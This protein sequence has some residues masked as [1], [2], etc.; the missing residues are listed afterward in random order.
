MVDTWTLNHQPSL[1]LQIELGIITRAAIDAFQTDHVSELLCWRALSGG[2]H[3]KT[4]A[5]LSVCSF[6]RGAELW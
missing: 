1:A 5:I 2:L 4:P 6:R 3:A